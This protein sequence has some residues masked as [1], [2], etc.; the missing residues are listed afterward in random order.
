MLS[1]HR[2]ALHIVSTFV[3]GATVL[4]STAQAQRI[5][6]S[7]AEDSWNNRMAGLFA[8]RVQMEGDYTFLSDSSAE[9]RIT[10]HAV[11]DMLLRYGLATA[12]DVRQ[13]PLP[14][15]TQHTA[16]F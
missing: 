6:D 7:L 9:T 8:G 2:L 3:L 10:Q 5:G 1:Q 15:S 4:T 16:V 13:Q 11:P 12:R 14:P